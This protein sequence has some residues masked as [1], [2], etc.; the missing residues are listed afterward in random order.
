MGNEEERIPEVLV[1]SVMGLCEGVK[2]RVR[3]DS[4]LSEEFEIK[5]GMHQASVPTPFLFALV[6]D[7]ITEFARQGALCESLHADDSPE[8]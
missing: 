3:V 1:R 8:E 4:V 7:V 2:T 6:V 5:V